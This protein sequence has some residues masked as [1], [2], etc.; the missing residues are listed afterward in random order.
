MPRMTRA[1]FLEICIMN[2]LNP[3]SSWMIGARLVL[4]DGKKV[5]EAARLVDIN[6]S[7]VTQAIKRVQ[8]KMDFCSSCGQRIRRKTA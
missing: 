8:R 5:G 1:E 7:N 2:H 3:H 4:V 6:S